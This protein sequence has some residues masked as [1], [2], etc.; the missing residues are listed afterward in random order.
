MLR[1]IAVAVLRAYLYNGGLFYGF[2]LLSFT[3]RGV[4]NACVVE[5]PVCV[6]AEG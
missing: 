3:E 5:D 6:V 2:S 1:L 4:V